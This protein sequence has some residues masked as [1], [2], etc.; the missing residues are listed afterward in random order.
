MTNLGVYVIP[1]LSL[2]T[3]YTCAH[4][5]VLKLYSSKLQRNFTDNLV[6][7]TC[8]NNIEKYEDFTSEKKIT[9]RANILWYATILLYI[10]YY[11][12]LL[13]GIMYSYV[14]LYTGH[15]TWEFLILIE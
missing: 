6:T 1:I 5:E 10:I 15:Q 7:L 12:V 2:V 13:Y 4:C 8:F 11:D 3:T 14:E 9:R